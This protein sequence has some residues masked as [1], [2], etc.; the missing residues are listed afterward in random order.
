MKRVIRVA[1]APA[2]HWV[3]DGFPVQSMF[4]YQEG[5][6][7]FS[8]FLLLDYAAPTT[9]SPTAPS[10]HR[11]GVGTH[12]HRGFETV[13][14]VYAGEV[15][16]RDSTGK[17]GVIGPG[18]VQWM[19][20]GGGILHEEFHSEAYS[21]SGG[22][23]QMVQLW[24]NLPAKDKLTAP[25]YQAIVDASIPAVSLGT[26]GAVRVI[27]GEYSGHKGPARTF[28]PMNVWDVQ[29]AVGQTVD[30]PQPDGWTTLLIVLG[31]TVQV[32]A[33]AVARE[34]QMVILSREGSDLH[35]EANNDARVLLLAGQPIDEPIVGYGPFVMNS[36][37]EIAQAIKDFNGGKFGRMS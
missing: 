29:L 16:H 15:E 30:L 28:T 33:D 18:D 19:T 17:G 37:Q 7:A 3:G 23:F 25:G 27:A 12:P 22:P 26:A 5:A 20:A 2:Q 10:D 13:T 35:I 11:R 4:S 34:S 8:P 36:K 21:R 14:I 24:V 1:Q 9:F 31:G 6:E 32:N